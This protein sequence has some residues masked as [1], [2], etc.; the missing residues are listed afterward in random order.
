VST[1]SKQGQTLGTLLVVLQFV[2]LAVLVGLAVLARQ[3]GEPL[4][5]EVWPPLV[6]SALLGLWALTANRPGN[7]NVH[8]VPREGGRLV[9]AGPYRWIRHPMYTAV[10]LFGGGCM[11]AAA[12][13]WRGVAWAVLVGV[14]VVKARLEEHWMRQTHPEYEAYMARSWRFVP[15]LH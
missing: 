6:L 13:G 15:G 2:A 11:F 4:L 5:W 10:I 7:F 3:A 12:S 9:Q 1:P 14:L 8:P